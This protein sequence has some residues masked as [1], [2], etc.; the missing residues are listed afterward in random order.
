M[1]KFV[2]LLVMVFMILV[3]TACSTLQAGERPDL[4]G[5]HF[6]YND[7]GEYIWL[8]MTLEDVE[9]MALG[10]EDSLEVHDTESIDESHVFY[11]RLV[12]SIRSITLIFDENERV[13]SIYGPFFVP[14]EPWFARGGI[15]TGTDLSEMEEAFDMNYVHIYEESDSSSWLYFYFTYD[16]TPVYR[17]SEDIYYRVVFIRNLHQEGKVESFHITRFGD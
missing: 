8:G 17:D 5:Y 3:L 9:R 13:Y 16:H 6:I 2:G 10:E 15:T 4:D 7:A 12:I 1:K 14:A 11:G